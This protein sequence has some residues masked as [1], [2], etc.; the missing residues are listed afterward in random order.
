MN[1]EEKKISVCFANENRSLTAERIFRELLVKKWYKVSDDLNAKRGRVVL[2][3]GFRPDVGGRQVTKELGDCVDEIFVMSRWMID[4]L[5]EVYKQDVRK[6]T[7]LD[8]PNAYRKDDPEL[9]SLLR[10]KLSEYLELE[11]Y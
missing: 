10:L 8:I 3:A 5:A 2:S 7:T 4:E 11:G 1:Y 9:I 6:I